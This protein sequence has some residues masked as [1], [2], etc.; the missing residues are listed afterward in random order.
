[1]VIE[2]SHT[3]ILIPRLNCGIEKLQAHRGLGLSGL[4]FLPGTSETLRV[5]ALIASGVTVTTGIAAVQIKGSTEDEIK[6]P[7]RNPNLENINSLENEQKELKKQFD[8]AVATRDRISDFFDNPKSQMVRKLMMAPYNFNDIMMAASASGIQNL[9]TISKLT[10]E[11][12]L[13]STVT[14][15]NDNFI[16]NTFY[17]ISLYDRMASIGDKK[18]LKEQTE[19]NLEIARVREQCQAFLD[20]EP[21]GQQNPNLH[22]KNTDNGLSSLIYGGTPSKGAS[23]QPQSNN[24]T[25]L[26]DYRKQQYLG[27]PTAETCLIN[28]FPIDHFQNPDKHDLETIRKA[29][30]E[31]RQGLEAKSIEQGGRRH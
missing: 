5:I 21:M 31:F 27:T 20:E 14:K 22:H 19:I 12:I 29:E 6:Y 28:P 1:M 23:Q 18:L 8:F 17:L 11:E 16:N 10:I 4:A 3:H 25:S 7:A 24:I 26:D 30:A 2:L 15:S 9:I 13:A